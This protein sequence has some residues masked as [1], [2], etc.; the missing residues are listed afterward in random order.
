MFWIVFE[1]LADFA[2]GTVDAVIGVQKDAVAPDFLYD[3]LA[4]D[5]LSSL[6]YQ[7]QQ[8]FHRDA[9]E[10]EGVTSATQL[11]GAQINLKILPKS[12]LVLILRGV[13]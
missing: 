3:F 9:F 2:D 11:V 6:L 8:D 7:E 12:H 1:D 13:A 5:Q 4:C 10:F